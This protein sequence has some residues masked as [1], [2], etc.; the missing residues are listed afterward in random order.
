M[1][2]VELM[3]SMEAFSSRYGT[4][5]SGT[6]LFHVRASARLYKWISC[7]GGVN[8]ILDRN[9]SLTEGFPEEGRNYFINLVFTF[10]K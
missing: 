5:V 2:L 7:E 10:E 6:A 1:P 8:N 3:G 9:Y 4:K